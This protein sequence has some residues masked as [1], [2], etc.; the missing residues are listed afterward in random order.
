VWMS[1]LLLCDK[2]FRYTGAA[3]NTHSA[4]R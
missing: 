4:N 2:K 1:L 3:L